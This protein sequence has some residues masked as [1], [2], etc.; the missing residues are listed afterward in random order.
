M[1]LAHPCRLGSP[2]ACRG[3]WTGL[4]ACASR[5]ECG[6]GAPH[7]R[8]PY[9]GSRTSQTR[10]SRCSRRPGVWPVPP[11][12]PSPRRRARALQ[13][14]RSV[15][16]VQNG[17]SESAHT[18]RASQRFSAVKGPRAAFS[19]CAWAASQPTSGR[20]PGPGVSSVPNA[21]LSAS[22][23]TTP[24]ISAPSEQCYPEGALLGQ[25]GTRSEEIGTRVPKSYGVALID[26]GRFAIVRVF[27]VRH[28]GDGSSLPALRGRHWSEEGAGGTGRM[29]RMS[30]AL[31]PSQ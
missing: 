19:L 24:R 10:R 30:A 13:R 20:P 12:P 27:R 25:G 8:L 5:C 17:V 23:A 1:P 22:A 18:R 14:L 16:A 4:L 6:S 29:G 2:P 21:P 15:G 28:C 31:A 7:P 9:S 11:G 26:R 3:T